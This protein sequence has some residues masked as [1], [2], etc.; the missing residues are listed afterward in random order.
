MV[1]SGGVALNAVCNMKLCET[2]IFDD[3]W[4]QPA[5]GDAGSAI[6]C[7]LWVWYDVLGNPRTENEI[8]IFSLIWASHGHEMP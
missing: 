3:V 8:T 1:M 6:G 4:V 2:G 5:A 7:A